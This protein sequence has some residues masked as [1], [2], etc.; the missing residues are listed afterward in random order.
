M[1]EAILCRSS[2]SPSPVCKGNVGLGRVGLGGGGGGRIGTT[3]ETGRE[4]KGRRQT[5]VKGSGE[6]FF[7]SLTRLKMSI[8]FGKE[9]QRSPTKRPLYVVR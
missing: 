6:G 5:C 8:C 4:R 1:R 2:V 9:R 3:Q 7:C